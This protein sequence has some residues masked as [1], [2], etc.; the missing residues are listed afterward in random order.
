MLTSLNVKK[1]KKN[2][3]NFK[4]NKLKDAVELLFTVSSC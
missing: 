2:V 3:I 4:T 1:K